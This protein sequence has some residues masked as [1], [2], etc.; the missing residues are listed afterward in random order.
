GPR[1]GSGGWRGGSA[2]MPTHGGGTEESVRAQ[3]LELGRHGR[4]ITSIAD[5]AQQCAPVL[6]TV[7]VD[8][9]PCR[10]LLN[11]PRQVGGGQDAH[12]REVGAAG[13]LAQPKP[14][15]EGLGEHIDGDQGGARL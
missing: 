6:V 14:T 9:G 12:G 7:E 1:P 15:A 13:E 4:T 10:P 8:E 11:R 2:S 3:R 5:A